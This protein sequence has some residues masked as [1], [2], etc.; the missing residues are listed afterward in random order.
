MD[1]ELQLRLVKVGEIYSP[2]FPIEIVQLF[3][4]RMEQIKKVLSIIPEKGKHAVVYGDRGVGKTSFSNIIKILTE[5]HSQVVRVSCNSIDSVESLWENI[6]AQFTI[7]YEVAT[8]TVSFK[9]TTSVLQNE[10]PLSDIIGQKK[11]TVKLILEM[12][13]YLN[14]P[15]IIIDEFDR[16]DSSYFNKKLFTDLVKSISDSLPTVTL[17][18]VGVSEDVSTLIQEHESIERNL[19]QI[20][21]PTMDAEEIREIILKGEEPLGIKYNLTVVEDIIRLSSGFPHFTHSLCSNSASLA[22]TDRT[23]IVSDEHFKIAVNQTINNAH[24]SLKNGYRIATLATKANIFKEVLFA[25]SQVT[26]DEYGYFQATDL[27]P[28]LEKIL[29]K[30]VPLQSYLTHLG[31]FCVLERGEVLKAVGGKNRKKYKFKNPLMKAFVRLNRT[32]DKYRAE[33]EKATL[34]AGGLPVEDKY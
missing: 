10:I 3:S 29:G 28:V 20:Y 33:L 11:I 8:T 24:E 14:R 9:P 23:N 6:F 27:S 26:P 12:L 17:I 5:A 22:I 18:I 1:A 15:V 2:S 7:P 13:P 19:S 34:T 32:N 30:P 4:G 25:A 21:M 16:V 31:K